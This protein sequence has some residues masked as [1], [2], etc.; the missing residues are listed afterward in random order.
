MN[1]DFK[2][3]LGNTNL[4]IFLSNCNMTNN[5]AV[6]LCSISSLLMDV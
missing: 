5:E 6:H 3:N 2:A 1:L 4:G